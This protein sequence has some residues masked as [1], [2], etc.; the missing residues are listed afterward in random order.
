MVTRSREERKREW[1][2]FV[3]EAE[4]EGEREKREIFLR[5]NTIIYGGHSK[6]KINFGKHQVRFTGSN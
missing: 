1:G 2:L 5:N 6:H 3:T 4:A